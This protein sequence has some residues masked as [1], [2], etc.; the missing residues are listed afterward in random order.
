[1]YNI[2]YEEYKKYKLFLNLIIFKVDCKEK[3]KIV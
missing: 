2:V 1:M 3:F